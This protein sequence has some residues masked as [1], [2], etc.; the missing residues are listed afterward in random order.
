VFFVPGPN[1]DREAGRNA[2]SKP[3]LRTAAIAQYVGLGPH[4]KR[5]RLRH[6]PLCR[7]SRAV[8]RGGAQP[9]RQ[10]R[11]SG[12]LRA[13]AGLCPTAIRAP[14]VTGSRV[15]SR[16]KTQPHH[17][18]SHRRPLGANSYPRPLQLRVGDGFLTWKHC[19]QS[20]HARQNHGEGDK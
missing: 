19:S 9:K 13:S 4:S 10:T 15:F 12:V 20:D 11:T 7:S 2:P 14:A 8:A 16:R 18:Q 5:R 3:A 6:S 1:V 17:A